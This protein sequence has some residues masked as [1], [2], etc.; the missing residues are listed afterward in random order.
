MDVCSKKIAMFQQFSQLFAV[1][2][3]VAFFDDGYLDFAEHAWPTLQSLG[4]PAVLF[5]PTAFPDHPG[6]GFWWDRLYAGPA[7]AKL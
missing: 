6:P 5:V 1:R 3:V 2:V 4:I 7:G